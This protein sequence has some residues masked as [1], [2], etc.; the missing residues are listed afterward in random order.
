MY[1]EQLFAPAPSRR[2]LSRGPSLAG[3]GLGEVARLLSSTWKFAP[4]FPDGSHRGGCGE[5]RSARVPARP[6][7]HRPVLAGRRPFAGQGFPPAGLAFAPS[8]L[9]ARW[10]S[11]DAGGGGGGREPRAS[12]GWVWGQLGV[13]GLGGV[14]LCF[15]LG[16]RCTLPP[17][18]QRASAEPP[19]GRRAP[20]PQEAEGTEGLP[21]SSWSR[22]ARGAPSRGGGRGRLGARTRAQTAARGASDAAWKRGQP[23]GWT[24]GSHVGPL[25]AWALKAAS[26]GRAHTP[27]G[28]CR[29]PVPP[30][31]SQGATQGDGAVSPAPPGAPSQT[32]VP[33][34]RPGA[35]PILRTPG[36][37]PW[38]PERLTSRPPAALVLPEPPALTT[39]GVQPCASRP[40]KGPA[41]SQAPSADSRSRRAWPLFPKLQPILPNPL[42]FIL[43]LHVTVNLQ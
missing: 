35:F 4:L 23:W 6:P 40:P 24:D 36:S 21:G 5:P 20:A 2:R 38:R 37:P 22:R 43:I 15:P 41:S 17:R 31:A 32:T 33:P 7:A 30:H 1:E 3:G 42:C 12:A 16:P 9:A 10:V 29:Y 26:V 14:G 11:V 13:T 18:P 25:Q 27:D 19:L 34:A 8:G 39:R 28:P